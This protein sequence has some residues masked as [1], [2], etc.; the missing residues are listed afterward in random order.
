MEIERAEFFQFARL[1]KFRHLRIE[2]ELLHEIRVVAAGVFHF[3][4]LHR[5]VL[6]NLVGGFTGE[7]FLDE[8]EEDGLAVPHPK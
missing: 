4:G 7:T 1:E 3:P 5:G 6:A 8:R 2:L